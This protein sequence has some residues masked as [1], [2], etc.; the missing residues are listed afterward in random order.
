[1]LCRTP[2]GIT[3]STRYVFLDVIARVFRSRTDQIQQAVESCDHRFVV[4]SLFEAGMPR[5]L[6]DGK[7][8]PVSLLPV[9]FPR[10]ERSRFPY[11]Q[12][13]VFRSGQYLVHRVTRP[14]G[15]LCTEY[16]PLSVPQ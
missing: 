4:S 11:T 10:S 12:P 3:P 7:T 6:I 5:E 1:M 8:D 15:P 2:S 14:I 9:G 16:L 13:V